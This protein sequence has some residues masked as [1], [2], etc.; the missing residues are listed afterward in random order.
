MRVR[1][2][3]GLA[4]ALVCAAV[5]VEAAEPPALAQ[6]RA[7]YNVGK[8]DAAI[9]AAASARLEPAFAD[10]A[11]LVMSRAQLERYRLTADPLDLSTARE[12]LGRIR[13]EALLPR[14]QVDLLIGLGQALY[15]GD[16]FGAAADVFDTARRRSALLDQGDRRRLLDWWATALD[17]AAQTRAPDQRA[18]LFERIARTMEAELEDDPGSAVANYWLVI[19]AR[20]AGELDR[21]WD[22]ALAA[23]VRASLTPST[24]ETLRADVDR[25]MT[26][27]LI[28]ERARTRPAREQ[29]DAASALRTEWDLV[30]QQWK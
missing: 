17:R 7:M 9:D 12:T 26:Q 24:T 16:R 10:A 4:V 18:A 3:P 22:A 13:L 27:A 21:A 14:D 19:A 6:A 29:Q 2:V 1:G 11:A 8:Y 30:K 28:P 5:A 23:W 15:L 25:L 20:G